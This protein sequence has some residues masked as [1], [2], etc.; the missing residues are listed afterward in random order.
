MVDHITK[1]ISLYDLGIKTAIVRYQLTSE[2]LQEET[3][4][5]EQGVTSSLGAIAVN[6]GE[7]TGRSPKDR[8]IV[9]DE[10]TKDKVWWSE[11]NLPF[12]ANKFDALYN[13]VT[14]YLSGK[15]LFVR[16][17]YACA[18]EGYKLAIRVINEYPWSNQF[19]FNMFIRPTVEELKEFSP[20]WIVV[21]APGF[22]AN[23]EEDGTRQHNFAILNFTKKNVQPVIRKIEEEFILPKM[24]K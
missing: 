15:E 13:K 9:K 20:E 7:F 16:D 18:D 17:S 23:P 22:M 11:M 2:E 8:F 1:S 5:K 24:K 12:D 4:K 3:I 21:N 19:A 10:V 6:T 14:A